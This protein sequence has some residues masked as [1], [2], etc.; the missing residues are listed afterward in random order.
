MDWRTLLEE[1]LEATFRVTL[2]LLD[3]VRDEDLDWK[4]AGGSNWMSMAQLLHHLGHDNA[5]A[6]FKGFVTGDWGLPEGFDPA[7]LKPEEMLPPAERMPAV[8]SV[9]EARAAVEADRRLALEML[10]R[11]GEK[12]LASQPAPAIWDPTP[13]PL[14]RRLLHMIQHLAQHKGQ[15]FYYLKLMGRPVG[16][17]ELWGA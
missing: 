3:H 6:C 4:P 7:Q 14:G 16:T 2:A 9:A 12:E 17:A 15:L 5:G 1:E 10:A 13:I 8:A 11:A